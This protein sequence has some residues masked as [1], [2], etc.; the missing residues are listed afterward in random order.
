MLA[1]EFLETFCK[2]NQLPKKTFTPEAQKKM[3]AHSFPG[4]VRELKAV[5]ELAAVMADEEQIK[6]EEVSFS[7]RNSLNHFLLEDNTLKDFNLKIMQHYLNRY[8]GNVLEVASKLDVGKSTIYRM[9]QN[10]ELVI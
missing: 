5:V 4:N 7:S 9:I 3:L 10:R 6:A 8:N 1:K 2:E